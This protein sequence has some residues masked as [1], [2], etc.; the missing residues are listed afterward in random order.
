VLSIAS[1]TG[2]PG[3]A[4]LK[5]TACPWSSTAVHWLA[6]GQASPAIEGC[7]FIASTAAGEDHERADA[8]AVPLSSAVQRSRDAT[9]AW[10]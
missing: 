8:L 4:G 6:E 9:M 3:E 2:L 1:G 10:R 7:L 5:V